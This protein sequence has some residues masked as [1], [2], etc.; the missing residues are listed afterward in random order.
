LL[1]LGPAKS[2]QAAARFVAPGPASS[3]DEPCATFG[4]AYDG[5]LGTSLDVQLGSVTAREARDGE[6]RILAEIDRLEKIL[7]PRDPASEFRRACAGGAAASPELAAVLAAYDLWSDRTFGALHLNLAGV[8]ALWREAAR[9]GREPAAAD[10][11]AAFAAPGARAIDALGKAYI[12]DRAVAVARDYAPAGLLNLG[13][14]LRAWGERSWRIAVANPFDPADNAPAL[15]EIPLRNA[16]IATSGG[17]ARNFTVGARRYSHLIDPRTLRPLALDRAATVVA[18]DCVSANALS[19]ALCVL[20]T[21]EAT[22]LARTYALDHLRVAGAGE[23]AA[24]RGFG[25]VAPI[26]P[27]AAALPAVAAAGAWPADFQ[28]SIDIALKS[29]AGQGRRVKRPYVAVWIE[30]AEHRLVRTVSVWGNEGRYVP[31]LTK[32]WRAIGGDR[33]SASSVTRA[34]RYPGAYTVAWDG[35]DNRGDPVPQGSY[36]VFVEINREHGHHVWESAPVTCGRDAATAALPDTAE[37]D[38]TT[39]AYGPRGG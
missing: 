7:S 27:A 12:V 28:V 25:A 24:T 11:A 34:T 29:V 9:T 39:I 8:T 37:P 21:R 14:D 22:P 32:W 15:A 4:F 23:P 38:A 10:L 13:G 35:R 26:A 31:E 16:A 5:V 36:T 18:A 19:T 20:D 30:D 1:A 6:E 33:F 17:Y 3:R 2:T